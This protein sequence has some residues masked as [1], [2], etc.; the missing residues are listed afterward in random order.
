[1]KSIFGLANNEE[2]A[3][4]I[5]NRLLSSNFRNA[6]ISVLLADKKGQTIY[7]RDT[8]KSTRDFKETTYEETNFAKQKPNK[9]GSFGHEKETKAPE[10][11][12]AGAITGGILGGSLGL[13]AGL[14]S[15]AI[16]GLG[17]FIAAGPLLAALSGS[18]VGGS[19]GLLIGGLVGLGIPEYV[20]KKYETNLKKG[21]V[22]ICVTVEDSKRAEAAENIMKKE[23]A[24][25]IS[26]ST[27][28]KS[29]R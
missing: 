8:T 11:A 12:T 4:R 2:H 3:D 14:G 7:E 17:A 13:L 18:A 27:V 25:D 23:G 10:G 5:V 15:I 28:S 22:L 1:M 21:N 24:T 9:K 16:P 19:L 29:A 26:V 6:E 20:A